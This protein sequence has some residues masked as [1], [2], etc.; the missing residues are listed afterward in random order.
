MSTSSTDAIY[1][2]AR[3]SYVSYVGTGVWLSNFL[4]AMAILPVTIV[5]ILS[6]PITVPIT[7]WKSI[8]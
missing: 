3:N 2:S 5:G 6:L 8:D 7:I 4:G 1:T